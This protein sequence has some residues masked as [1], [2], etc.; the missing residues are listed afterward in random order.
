MNP[1]STKEYQEQVELAYKNGAIIQVMTLSGWHTLEHGMVPLWSWE[2][3]DYRLKP[4]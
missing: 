3:C 2:N 4:E 1:L